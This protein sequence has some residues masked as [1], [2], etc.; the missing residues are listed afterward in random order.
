VADLLSGSIN[1]AISFAAAN[2]GEYVAPATYYDGTETGTSIP[3]G[4]RF[5]FPSS[6]SMPSG[7]TPFAQMVFT[8]IQKYGA[9]LI[10]TAGNIAFYTENV[11]SW[12]RYFGA[13]PSWAGTLF[14]GS[15]TDYGGYYF[16][17]PTLPLPWGSLQATIPESA[18]NIVAGVQ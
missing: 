3:E 4:T 17:Y 6:V 7:L 12:T 13:V 10:D 9:Y 1:H 16:Y 2:T 15:S 5:F 11:T 18:A 14:G 8:A